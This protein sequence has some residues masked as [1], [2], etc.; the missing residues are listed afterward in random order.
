M[1]TRGIHPCCLDL[2]R[3]VHGRSVSRSGPTRD[4]QNFTLF[5]DSLLCSH[6]RRE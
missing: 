6:F 5:V 2:L 3:E 1:L 4:E